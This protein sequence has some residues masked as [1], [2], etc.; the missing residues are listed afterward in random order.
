[1]PEVAEADE[2]LGAVAEQPPHVPRVKRRRRDRVRP[3]AHRH[4]DEDRADDRER[5]GDGEHRLPAERRRGVHE[6]R[7][8]RSQ[9][10]R[11]DER[12]DGESAPGTKPRRHQLDAGR[13]DAGEGDAGQEAERD[14]GP[15]PVSEQGDRL[16]RGRPGER[17]QADEA[18]GRHPVREVEDRRGERSGDEPELHRRRE[19]GRPGIREVPVVAQLGHDRRGRE[20][21]AHR[22]HLDRADE[23]ELA[24]A[25]ALLGDHA[26]TMPHLRGSRGAMRDA[27]RRRS[28]TRSTRPPAPASACGRAAQRARST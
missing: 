2:P 9:G 23:Q 14:R 3:L 13:I 11:A 4:D 28:P 19:P 25:A 7:R 26:V 1:M 5:A 6:V 27:P 22:E 12:A 21:E 18:R 20:P 10:Q 16:V 24:C 15:Q 17:R 8:A